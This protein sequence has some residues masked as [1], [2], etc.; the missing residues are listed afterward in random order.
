MTDFGTKRQREEQGSNLTA[1]ERTEGRARQSQGVERYQEG[2]Y[3]PS[4]FSVSPGEFFTMS[5]ITLM[6]RFTEDIDRAF[7]LGNGF[8]RGQGLEQ[9]FNWVPAVEVRQSGNSLVIH[10]DLPGL[11]ENDVRVEGTEE[12][13]AIHGERRR[14]Q[15]LEEGGWRHSERVYGRFYRV[16][17]LPESAKIEEAKANFRNGVL[18][19]VVPVPQLEK[20]NRQIPVGSSNQS[21]ISEPGTFGEGRARAATSGR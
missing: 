7:G 14:E 11:T 16:I 6:R 1:S 20:R 3:L 21:L 8:H 4:V 10:A 18:E 15:T 9:E 17:P 5:P 13:L 19:V 12:G 2:R